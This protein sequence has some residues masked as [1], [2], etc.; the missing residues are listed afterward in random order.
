[1]TEPPEPTKAARPTEL[2]EPPEPKRPM[3][4]DRQGK[5][6]DR[7]LANELLE[8]ADYVRVQS[9]TLEPYL[10]STIWLA[11]NA[12]VLGTKFLLFETVVISA[13]QARLGTEHSPLVVADLYGKSGTE[14]EALALHARY[15][16]EVRYLLEHGVRRPP[17]E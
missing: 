10:V 11:R 14:A 17:T 6:I 9:T 2:T 12:N 7:M 5:P 3:W 15:V 13:E 1:M 16:D 8:R 4:F